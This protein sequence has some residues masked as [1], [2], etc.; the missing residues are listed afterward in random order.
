VCEGISVAA[1][2]TQDRASKEAQNALRNLAREL[3]VLHINNDSSILLLHERVKSCSLD[4]GDQLGLQS[5]R[6]GVP[7]FTASN[8]MIEGGFGNDQFKILAFEFIAK[9]RQ[10]VFCPR[11]NDPK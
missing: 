5:A 11:I 4:G 8:E 2:G 3:A 6:A 1:R 7:F 10:Y 9:L